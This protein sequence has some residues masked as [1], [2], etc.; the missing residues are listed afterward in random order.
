MV[1]RCEP[2]SFFCSDS[3][4]IVTKPL[5]IFASPLKDPYTSLYDVA[6]KKRITLIF[7]G[8]VFNYLKWD[9]LNVSIFIKGSIMGTRK[10]S[11]NGL[12]ECNTPCEFSRTGK[13]H[14]GGVGGN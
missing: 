13:K 5:V 12:K 6:Q 2:V 10:R 1:Y 11:I 3:K 4:Y 8:C 14:G 7:K 9:S